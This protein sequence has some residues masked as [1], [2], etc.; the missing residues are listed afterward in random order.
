MRI[1]FLLIAIFCAVPAYGQI[2]M[3][4]NTQDLRLI[5]HIDEHINSQKTMQSRFVQL[6]GG[7][8]F[9]EGTVSWRR[10]DQAR[11]DYD[12]PS[13]LLLI[14]SGT[15]LIEVDRELEQVTHYP[16]IGSIA[17]YLLAEDMLQNP[18][19]AISSLDIG[20]KVINI[21]VFERDAPENGIIV[22]SFDAKTFD[23]ERWT[24]NSPDGAHTAVN[25][26]APEFNLDLEDKIFHFRKPKEW[27]LQR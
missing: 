22:L 7:G 14:A 11:F 26:I 8:G 2:P 25:L 4:L 12:P 3:D 20:V 15:F 5:Q 16:Q 21:G 10:P 17:D 19:L 27:E 18:E 1:F 23:L 24:I 9:L 13:P 6:D